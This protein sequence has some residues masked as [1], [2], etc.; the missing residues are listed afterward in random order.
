MQ[1]QENRTLLEKAS[2]MISQK[3]YRFIGQAIEKTLQD[4]RQGDIQSEEG[5][6]GLGSQRVSV[7]EYSDLIR[8]TQQVAYMV[9]RY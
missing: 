6:L 8:Y 7:L 3:A 4:W 2:I 5:D 9:S 1:I